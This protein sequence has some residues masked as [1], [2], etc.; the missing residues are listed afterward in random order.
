MEVR[1]RH[2]GRGPPACDGAAPRGAQLGNFNE[3]N[4]GDSDERR[5]RQQLLAWAQSQRIPATS[6]RFMSAF[7]SRN[8]GPA[9]KRL[10]DLA[11]NSFAWYLDDPGRE[12]AWYDIS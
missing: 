12:L 2:P 6:C 8:D 5:H 3:Q 10:K 4:W 11:V 1:D 7:A 9:K